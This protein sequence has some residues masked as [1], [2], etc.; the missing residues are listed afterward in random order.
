MTR[1]LSQDLQLQ[2]ALQN[3][4]A[5]VGDIQI[6]HDSIVDCCIQASLR[7]I[8][9]NR[10]GK[11]RVAGWNAYVRPQRDT[12]LFWNAIWVQC[13][14]PSTGPVA[15]IRRKTRAEYHRS[16]K[17]VKVHSQS[18]ESERMAHALNENRSRDFWK[19]V[20]KLS[21]SSKSLDGGQCL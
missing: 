12:A 18:L 2:Q 3:S 16:V 4:N 19:E 1:V 9:K 17:W 15:S 6:M 14:R 11:K 5:T 10:N 21:C 20:K 8:P 7:T 13:G